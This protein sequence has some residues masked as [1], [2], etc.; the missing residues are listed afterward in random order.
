[1]SRNLGRAKLQ[2]ECECDQGH[3]QNRNDTGAAPSCV[4]FNARLFWN[5]GFGIHGG[6][7]AARYFDTRGF[8]FRIAD[9]TDRAIAIDLLKLVLIDEPI[10]AGG[11]ITRL[12]SK[13]PKHR[14]H[15]RSTCVE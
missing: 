6:Q 1:M 3:D 9:Q 4:R 12:S 5:D 2:I 7:Q 14:K 10:A 13:R 11:A 8:G 15:C